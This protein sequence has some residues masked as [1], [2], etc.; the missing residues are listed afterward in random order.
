MH[1][2]SDAIHCIKPEGSGSIYWTKVSINTL[3]SV[4]SEG[5]NSNWILNTPG[6]RS[7]RVCPGRQCGG[8]F[9]S[10][11]RRQL[12]MRLSRVPG[13]YYSVRDGGPVFNGRL[14]HTKVSTNT[15]V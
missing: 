11:E 14:T 4:G 1:G 15:I 6:G 3:V 7:S 2:Y 12:S 5:S 8:Q 9:G 10:V 13:R